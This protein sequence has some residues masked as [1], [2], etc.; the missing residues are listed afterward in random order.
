MAE[1][2]IPLSHYV[3]YQLLYRSGKI[4][5]YMFT[6]VYQSHRKLFHLTSILLTIIVFVIFSEKYGRNIPELYRMELL[7][8]RNS[9]QYSTRYSTIPYL[10][11][12]STKYSSTKNSY[13]S[14]VLPYGMPGLYS[15]KTTIHQKYAKFS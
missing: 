5:M 8:L 13:T 12:H 15:S 9:F 4:K 3:L 6:Y 11:S 2:K 10:N 14:S 1:L 7:E